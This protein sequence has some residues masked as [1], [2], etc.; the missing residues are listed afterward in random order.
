MMSRIVCS[1]VLAVLAAMPAL[2]FADE[3][4]WEVLRVYKFADGRAVAVTFPAEWRELNGTGVLAKGAALRFVDESGAPV[5]I[6]SAAL[7]RASATK[8]VLRAEDSRELASR[9]T[10]RT[11]KPS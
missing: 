7:E 2:S 3:T 11:R 1:L 8:S 9:V 4:R 6:P 5:R 10:Y